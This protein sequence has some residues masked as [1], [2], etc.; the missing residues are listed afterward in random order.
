VA[1]P[2]PV[3]LLNDDLMPKVSISTSRRPLLSQTPVFRYVAATQMAA[4]VT[5][6]APRTT[7]QDNML[8]TTY[9][10]GLLGRSGLKCRRFQHEK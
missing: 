1:T 6:S 2:L 8:W 10:G 9:H 4:H 5:E 7:Q 3:H